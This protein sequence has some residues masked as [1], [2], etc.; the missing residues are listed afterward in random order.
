MKQAM[1]F[2]PC[3][4]ASSLQVVSAQQSTTTHQHMPATQHAYAS[5]KTS[6]GSNLHDEAA[7]PA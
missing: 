3:F 6:G 5:C 1:Q 4:V 2:N 7:M